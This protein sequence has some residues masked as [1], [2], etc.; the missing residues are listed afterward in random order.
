[1][2]KGPETLLQ[3][4]R[5]LVIASPG[6]SDA[7]LLGRFISARDERAFTALVDR[8]GALVL[9]VCQRILGDVHDAEDAFQAVF[10]VLAR[11]AAA[12]QPRE[13]LAAW[14][15]GVARRVALKALAARARQVREAQSPTARP[16]DPRPDPLSELSGRELVKIIDEELQRLPKVYRLPTILCCLQGRSL[17][18]AARQLGWTRGSVKG[19]L[20]RGR[21]RLHERLLRRDLTLPAVLAAVGRGDTKGHGAGQAEDRGG[22]HAGDVFVGIGIRYIHGSPIALYDGC[23][24]SVVALS[25]QGRC[26]LGCSPCS[27]QPPDDRATG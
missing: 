9:H 10:L 21:A 23:T 22:A 12:V 25:P 15:H 8:H 13:A 18:E 2:A 26:G 19:R 6:D 5:R 16:A 11:K 4:V 24:C 3:Y 20:E 27:R 14:L 17:E 7:A 1:M